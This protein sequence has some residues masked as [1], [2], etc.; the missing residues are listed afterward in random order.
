MIR[1]AGGI[2][3]LVVLGAA[4]ALAGPEPARPGTPQRSTPPTFASGVQM[5]NLDVLVTRAGRALPGLVASDFLVTDNGVPQQVEV[6]GHED[7]AVD[8][9]LALDASESVSGERLRQLQRAAHAFVDALW[10]TDSVTLVGFAYDLR[11][12]ASAAEERMKS[13]AAI[14]RFRGAGSTSLSDAVYAA[15][16][17]SDPRRGRPLVLVFSDGQDHG[18]WLAPE[19]VAAVAR[20]SDAVIHGVVVGEEDR[21]FLEGVAHDSGGHV[22]S[23]RHDRELRDTFVA[24][25]D[26][27][28]SRYRLRYDPQGVRP[29][30]WHTLSVKLKGRQ[31]DV[32][33][34]RGYQA[35]PARP[36]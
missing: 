31:G 20:S 23:A 33:V 29:E 12:A 19:T 16:L 30:G 22:W 8:A 1:H 21:S 4:A 5:V 26:E 17:L 28:K 27:F 13:Q 25:L 34:R 15:L 6:L 18:S 36:R 11:L 3:A 9:V 10:P 2:T 24:A 32:R 14:E 7:T 35:G